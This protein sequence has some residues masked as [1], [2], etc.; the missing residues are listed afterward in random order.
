MEIISNTLVYEKLYLTLWKLIPANLSE[1]ITLVADNNYLTLK[2]AAWLQNFVITDPHLAPAK[3][4]Y[5]IFDCD[6][7]VMYLK[8]KSSL[9]AANTS[10]FNYPLAVGFLLTVKHAFN[11]GITDDGSLFVLNTQSSTRDFLLFD[12]A[13]VM[14]SFLALSTTNPIKF[15]YI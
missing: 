13:Q 6:D 10:G 12:D 5:D 1:T 11:F 8:T 7:Y 14:S 9:F 4:R 2:D 3:Y 15:I